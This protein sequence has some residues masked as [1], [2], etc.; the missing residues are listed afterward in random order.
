MRRRLIRIVTMPLADTCRDFLIQAA[1]APDRPTPF[2]LV[3]RLATETERYLDR[4]RFDPAQYVRH[5]ILLWED[6]EVMVIGWEAVCYNSRSA[7][8]P[9]K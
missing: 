8:G 4:I 5:A 7:G 1:N 2:S 6:W 3:E 9:R